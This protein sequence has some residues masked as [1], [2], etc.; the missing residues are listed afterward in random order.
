MTSLLLSERLNDAI[1]MLLADPGAVLPEAEEQ[2][3]ELVDIARELRYLPRAE[4]RASL[5][6]GLQAQAA[7][8]SAATAEL[9]LVAPAADD[10][11]LRS[12]VPVLP[13]L[14]SNRY[15]TYPMHGASFALSF[16]AHAAALVL[17]IGSGVWL[18]QQGAELRRPIVTLVADSSQYPL[19]P[20]PDEAA[21]GGGGGDADHL[22]ASKGTPPRFAREQMAPPAVV[23]RNLE[24]KLAATPTVV[25]PPKL[26]FPAGPIGIPTANLSLPS[27]GPGTGGGIGTGTGGGVGSGTGPG[28]GAGIG[29]GLGGG[30][31]RVGG[32]VSAPRTIYDPDPDYSDEARKARYQGVVVLWAVIGTDGRPKE[33]QVA[34]SLGMGLDEKAIEAVRKWRFTPA[35]KDGHPV[36]VLISIEVNFRLY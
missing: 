1:D 14:L 32:G 30:V 31:Y 17:L 12:E 5:D 35:L 33:L 10:E 19:P 27:N 22:A 2:V 15:V 11:P 6:V 26:V 25:G 20:A 13:T 29:G 34:R 7:A 9:F 21:G 23:I 28:V 18:T 36:P 24:P 4:F 16:L 3:S 8:M